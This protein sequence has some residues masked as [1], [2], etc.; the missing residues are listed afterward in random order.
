MT[1][2]AVTT[3]YNICILVRNP[4]KICFYDVIFSVTMTAENIVVKLYHCHLNKCNV[5]SSSMLG[6]YNKM[7]TIIGKQ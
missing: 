7:T 4:Q 2:R 5:Y 3:V 6:E 1:V